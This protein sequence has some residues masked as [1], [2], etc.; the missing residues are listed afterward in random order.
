MAMRMSEW[1]IVNKFPDSLQEIAFLF[2]TLPPTQV[3][4][5]RIFSALK[6][7]KSDLRNRLKADLVNAM[8]FLRTNTASTNSPN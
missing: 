4:V 3:S 7:L 5:E 1:E 2:L 8:L 6:I